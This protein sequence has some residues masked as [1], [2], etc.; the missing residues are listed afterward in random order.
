M[1]DVIDEDV[2]NFNYYWNEPHPRYGGVK[3]VRQNLQQL[4]HLV[5]HIIM[6][7]NLSLVI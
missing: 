1:G 2:D 4:I 5:I 6:Y 3:E 7:E